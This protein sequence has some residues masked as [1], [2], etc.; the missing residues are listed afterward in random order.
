LADFPEIWLDRTMTIDVEAKA[1]ERAVV[2]IKEA[3]QLNVVI[4]SGASRVAI[5]RTPASAGLLR[6]HAASQ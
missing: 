6:P 3:V 1:K 2:A 4:A 5:P